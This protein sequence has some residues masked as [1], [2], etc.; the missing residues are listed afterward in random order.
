MTEGFDLAVKMN[1]HHLDFSAHAGRTQLLEFV[2]KIRPEKVIA[3]HGDHCERF[4]TELRGRFSVD[5]I[6][7]KLGEIIEI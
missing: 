4:A 7:P 3:V 1:I 6:A 2:Q 5:A